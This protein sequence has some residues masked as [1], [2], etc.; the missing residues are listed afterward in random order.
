MALGV[1]SDQ[2]PSR[3]APTDLG[4]VIVAPFQAAAKAAL[5][6][7]ELFLLDH[8][9][10]RFSRIYP[11][12]SGPMNPF[13]SIL[14][15][16]AVENQTVMNAVLALSGAQLGAH[17][18]QEII[19]ATLCAR[20]R[21]LEGCRNILIYSESLMDSNQSRPTGRSMA[22]TGNHGNILYTL[23]S[24]ICL[25]LYEKLMG[26]GKAN[27]MPHLS[28]LAGLF[29]RL[30]TPH[31]QEV[32]QSILRGHQQRLAFGFIHNLFLYNDLVQSTAQGTS[33][34]SNF[35]LRPQGMSSVRQPGSGK[36]LFNGILDTSL[37]P[38]DLSSR[39]RFYYPYLIAQISAGTETVS[40]ASIGLWDSRLDWLPSFS[41]LTV[42]RS[43]GSEITRSVDTD[44][45]SQVN[46]P[47]HIFLMSAIYSY[48]A[49]LYLRQTRCR[50]QGQ[51]AMSQCGLEIADLACHATFLI[52][53]VPDG[54]SFENALLWPIGIIGPGLS[55]AS[56]PSRQYLLTRLRSLEQRFQMKHFERLQEV[57]VAGWNRLDRMDSE[58][59]VEN[60]V[61]L[62]G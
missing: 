31:N 28:F 44:Q 62:F 4:T 23:A 32:F 53:Q 15:P 47:D 36:S 60:D 58:E 43:P 7:H 48:T 12:C 51:N 46:E 50:R 39:D 26:D 52:S 21:A 49:K 27:W 45:S 57:L 41:V 33:T 54:S 5:T 18:D 37:V 13:L 55:A 59:L 6:T 2:G 20:H 24:C 14:L 17:R 11:T 42:P 22:G 38:G 35:Y 8:Y 16:L 40:D 34:L 61:F 30:E 9:I 29:D 10:Q 56:S 19:K 3:S 1:T 25:L